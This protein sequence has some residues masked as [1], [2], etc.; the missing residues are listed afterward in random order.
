MRLLPVG[1]V[2][3][4]AVL[5]FEEHAR[6]NQHVHEKARLPLGKPERLD[7]IDPLLA[8]AG[9]QRPQAQIAHT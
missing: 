2:G 1:D 8:D 3:K 6:V 4:R 9:A 5:T 7:G